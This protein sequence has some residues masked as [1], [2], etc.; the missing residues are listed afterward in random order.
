VIRTVILGAMAL[1]L[2]GVIMMFTTPADVLHSQTPS[3][4]PSPTATETPQATQTPAPT[5]TATQTLPPTPVIVQACGISA[6]RT[7]PPQRLSLNQA[8][9]RSVQLPDGTYIINVL[10]N[11]TVLFVCDVPT[12]SS[13]RFDYRVGC[14]LSRSVG[15]VGGAAV[16]NQIASGGA[17]P[18]STAPSPGPST[19]PPATGDGGLHR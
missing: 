7:T 19:R 12:N 6:T 8:G 4:T 10:E 13:I 11:D 17:G 3:P 14:E 9:S 5:P 2:A 16:L 18:C 1:T 15:S